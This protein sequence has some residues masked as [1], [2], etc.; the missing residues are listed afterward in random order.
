VNYTALRHQKEQT[1]LNERMVWAFSAS[2]S[3]THKCIW[4]SHVIA[5]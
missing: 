1:K 3:N 5:C 2:T 4:I